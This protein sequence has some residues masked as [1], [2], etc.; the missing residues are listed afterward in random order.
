MNNFNKYKYLSK[1]D[2]PSDLK[3][4]PVADLSVV[5]DEV[6]DFM[7]ETI[8]QTGG[9]FGSGL[10]AVEL[11]TALHY[12]YDT[13]KDK[14]VFD[15]GHQSYP[16]KI[17]TGRKELL[18]TIRKQGGISGFLKPAESEY[19]AFGAGHAST[20]ISAALG[21]ATARDLCGDKYRVLAVIG[22]GAMTGGMA[23]EALNNCGVQARDITVILN[24]NNVS[25]D[26][27][28]SAMSKYF[29]NLLSSQPMQKMRE[30]I[31]QLTGKMETF[32]DRIRK[33][34]SRIE[35]GVKAIITP[36]IL[37]EAFGFNYF[38]PI[39]GH[40]VQQLVRFLRKIKDMHGPL[41]LH[42]MTNKGQG[43]LPAEHD[44]Y[45][46]HA[47]EKIDLV[48]GKSIPA[49]GGKRPPKYSKVFGTAM[50]QL[51]RENPKIV[52]ITAAMGDG[53]GLDDLAKELP[54]QYFDVGI[55]EE[56][57]VTFAA[58]LAKQGITPVVAIYSTFLQ[59]AYDQIQHDCALPGLHVVFALDRAGL[60]GNDGPTHHG[61]LDIPYLRSIPGMV[62]MAP[63]DEQELRNMLNFAINEYK[64][65]PISIRFPRGGGMGT[66]IL[67]GFD[68]I[69]F[70]K[71][72]TLTEG[73]DIAIIAVGNMVKEALAAAD[74][75]KN[76]GV[77]A[78]VI[79]ARFLKPI[80]EAALNDVFKRHKYII[81]VEDGQTIGGFGSAV[82]EFMAQTRTT[83]VE[84][85][86]HG[87]HDKY[88]EHG[89]QS[90]ILHDELLDAVGIEIKALELLDKKR[91]KNN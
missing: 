91:L 89:K 35:G 20:S 28:V 51:A 36:G 32:G 60:V 24:D 27:N 16:H 30:N 81:T 12:V 22:D 18:H 44:I 61:I 17:L 7:I 57:A 38:G 42:V 50:V 11:I 43:Y 80:D 37:F 82:L 47:I 9:H 56:H 33:A 45:H 90:D 68:K 2:N 54:N 86:V 10:G 31:W 83:G 66:P 4:V 34:A 69:E 70:A 14:I 52:G 75:L 5:C 23:Y 85:L 88:T 72:E 84:V 58:G 77:S 48:T 46:M 8:T 78:E 74:L 21:M 63:K 3:H 13:P 40:N 64:S 6:R 41:L 76:K 29:N 39:D 73:K 19:D 26:V 65:G 67:P 62:S 55:A 1:I 49:P 71:S 15:V 25:I 87:L 59:R 79:N 53:T